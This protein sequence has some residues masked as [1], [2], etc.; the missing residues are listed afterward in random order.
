MSSGYDE[1]RVTKRFAGKD[2]AGFIQKPYEF[3]ELR[4]AMRSALGS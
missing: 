2:L 1:Q 4:N 3:K